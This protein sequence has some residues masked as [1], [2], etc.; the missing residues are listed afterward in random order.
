MVVTIEKQV[1]FKL[2][3][4]GLK[5]DENSHAI[6][7]ESK[8]YIALIIKTQIKSVSSASA[9]VSDHLYYPSTTFCNKYYNKRYPSQG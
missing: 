6:G 2:V 5:S 4:K 7:D 3:E 9:N 1:T 8:I